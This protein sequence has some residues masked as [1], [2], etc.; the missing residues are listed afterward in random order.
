VSVAI[1]VIKLWN[2]DKETKDC[3]HGLGDQVLGLDLGL[4]GQVLINITA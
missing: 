1:E 2:R 4:E 3:C